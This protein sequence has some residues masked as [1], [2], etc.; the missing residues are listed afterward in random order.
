MKQRYQALY[1][2][3]KYDGLAGRQQ[4]T[5]EA[6][7]PAPRATASRPDPRKQQQQ[8]QHPYYQHPQNLATAYRA[9]A[10]AQ[11]RSKIQEELERSAYASLFPGCSL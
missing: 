7:S 2:K 11:V 3:A 5:Q 8:Q 10:G 1:Y 9:V 4:S 6:H